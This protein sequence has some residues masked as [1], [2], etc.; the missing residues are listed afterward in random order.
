R[1][2]AGAEG[3]DGRCADA[4]GGVRAVVAGRRSG[5]ERRTDDRGIPAGRVDGR[6]LAT[7]SGGGGR[8][9]RSQV[10]EDPNDDDIDVS[11]PATWAA[12]VPGVLHAL[13]HSLRGMG[14][15]R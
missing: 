13:D 15:K 5:R 7:G 10:V 9:K 8:V 1:V 4:G 2:R 12:G 6:V 14:V 11:E 3:L